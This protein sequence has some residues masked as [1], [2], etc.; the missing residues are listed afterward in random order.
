MSINAFENRWKACFTSIVLVSLYPI[1][2]IFFVALDFRAPSSIDNSFLIFINVM[3]KW[4]MSI[5]MGLSLYIYIVIRLDF[6]RH[7]NKPNN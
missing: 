3:F 4:I 2:I 5:L 1:L 7:A 6:Y